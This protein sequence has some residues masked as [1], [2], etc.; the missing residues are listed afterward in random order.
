M[1][2]FISECGKKL[3]SAV[4]ASFH[5]LSLSLVLQFVLGGIGFAVLF[6]IFRTPDEESHYKTGLSN[7]A[8]VT[9]GNSTYCGYNMD[10]NSLTGQPDGS[11]TNLAFDADRLQERCEK[12][13]TYG[14]V[15]NYPSVL[16]AS[17]FTS[18]RPTAKKVTLLHF[19]LSRFMNGFFVA[20]VMLRLVQLMSRWGPRSGSFFILCFCLS[21]L[22][23]QQSWSVTADV[24]INLLGLQL[25]IIAIYLD[26][27]DGWDIGVFALTSIIACSS[28]PIL[29]PLIPGILIVAYGL[30]D[31]DA[32]VS[33]SYFRNLIR[34]RFFLI[35][36]ASGVMGIA[37]AFLQ[38]GAEQS[39]GN[40]RLPEQLKFVMDNPIK[41]F[42]LLQQCLTDFFIESIHF[43]AGHLGYFKISTPEFMIQL[44]PKI[45][46]MAVLVEAVILCHF[47]WQRLRVS[48]FR[49]LS[50]KRLRFISIASVFSAATLYVSALIPIFVM[51]L[52]WTKIG[53]TNVEGVQA[54]YFYPVIFSGIGLLGGLAGLAKL[55]AA[56]FIPAKR[57]DT[58]I[59]VSLSFVFCLIG[60]GYW[61]TLL[62]DI[63]RYYY[64]S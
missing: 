21:P 42:R 3:N 20:A 53:A 63:V 44:Y 51:F 38:V 25:A 59:K 58:R 4:N 19:Y 47:F 17:A 62:Y 23:L 8:W 52:V 64:Q 60:L 55:P 37:I 39:K 57:H 11:I 43:F 56:E 5:A 54:R 26:K 28:K 10:L 14:W 12:H 30:H 22:F 41:T 29:A 18:D 49:D 50:S 13:V 33:F 2:V 9:R 24:P 34:Q 46:A 7:Y 31:S 36:S 45:L 35:G 27:L 32:R 61:L 1:T 40:P 15:L 16:L 6:P 48:D